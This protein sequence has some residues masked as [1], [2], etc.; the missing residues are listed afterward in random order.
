MPHLKLDIYTA[1][2]KEW[3]RAAQ[4]FK[5]SLDDL[6]AYCAADAPEDTEETEDMVVRYTYT[7]EGWANMAKR[8]K[9]MRPDM[10]EGVPR[11]AFQRTIMVR[12]RG[13]RLFLTPTE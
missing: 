1:T 6:E 2:L 9:P 11:G 13:R 12:C 5:G 4:P 3:V 7:P 10:R 8:L